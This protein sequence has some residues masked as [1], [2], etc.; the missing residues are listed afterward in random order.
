MDR[1]PSPRRA[2]LGP[3]SR[4]LAAA[5]CS[6]GAELAERTR[7]MEVCGQREKDAGFS[8][9]TR[10]LEGPDWCVSK[11]GQCS[12]ILSTSAWSVGWKHPLTG[13]SPGR[14]FLL[15]PQ[16]LHAQLNAPALSQR[17]SPTEV[18]FWQTTNYSLTRR[19]TGQ[20]RNSRLFV[21]SPGCAVSRPLV[22]CYF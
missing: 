17:R 7:W 4:W 13:H 21:Y 11:A 10:F 8:S 18:N 19:Q 14:G 12:C 15:L 22:S 2:S 9:G 6:L 20:W 3:G 5:I 1:L 16:Q